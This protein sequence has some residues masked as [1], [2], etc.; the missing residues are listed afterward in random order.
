MFN[1]HV[2]AFLFSVFSFLWLNFCYAAS[3]IPADYMEPGFSNKRDY[4]GDQPNEYIDPFGGS[5]HLTYK[6]LVV[7]GNGGM[8]IVV[9]RVY[10]SLTETG[11]YLSNSITGGGRTTTGIGWDVHFGRVWPNGTNLLG[12][13][14]PAGRKK[15]TSSSSGNPVL[16]LADG[17]RKT[18]VDSDS[19][20]YS[21]ITKD[22]WIAKA[23]TPAEDVSGLGGLRVISPEGTE[24]LFTHKNR[25]ALT[26]AWSEAPFSITKITD[27]NGNWMQFYYLN[28]NFNYLTTF[29]GITTSDGRSVSFNYDYTNPNNSTSL[30]QQTSKAALRSITIG[31]QTVQYNYSAYLDGD[32]FQFL[33]RVVRPDN[34]N[35]NYTYY[36]STDPTG[37]YSLW[38]STSPASVKSTYTYAAVGFYTYLLGTPTNRV[39]SQKT[40]SGGGVTSG[41]WNYAYVPSTGGTVNDKTTVTSPF[42]C[43]VYQHFGVRQAASETVWKIGTLASKKVYDNTACT[44]LLHQEDY[45]WD[46]LTVAQQNAT[47][48]YISGFDS[49]TYDAKQVQKVITRDGTTYTTTYPIGNFDIYGNPQVVTEA[50]QDTKTTNYTYYNDPTKWI[51]GK[52]DK[53]TIVSASSHGDAIIDRTFDTLGRVTKQSHFSSSSTTNTVDTTYSYY[54]TG[55]VQRVTDAENNYV[56]YSNYYRGIPQAENYYDSSNTL[57]KSKSR[58]VDAAANIKSEIDGR[59][60]NTIYSYDSLNRLK[61]VIKPKAGSSAINITWT[62]NSSGIQ[63]VV[64]RG[65]YSQTTQ[66][67]GLGRMLSQSDNSISR[68]FTND[69]EGRQISATNPVVSSTYD[70]LGRVKTQTHKN[71]ANNNVSV[72][73]LYQ[74]AN[75]VRIT[76]EL[77]N[78]TTYSYL[79]YGNPD[80]KQ[81]ISIAA[82]HSVTTTITRSGT[83]NKLGLVTSVTQGGVTRS[84]SYNNNLFLYQEINPETGTTTYGRDKLGRMTSRQVGTSAITNFV[85][86]GLGRLKIANYPTGTDDVV[87]TYDG[88]DN[89]DTTTKGSNFWAYT[90][91]SN[92]NL[93]S[94][95]LTLN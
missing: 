93:E 30:I 18:L 10:H 33:D 59:G 19:T 41:T 56:I 72:S 2:L 79:S 71:D 6:D 40:V 44:T 27:K 89:L 94:E 21:F 65:T 5:L 92:D 8:D 74:A 54:A 12:S 78:V 45:T 70:Y 69:A 26:Q 77:S 23:I 4:T 88:N 31:A 34:T 91:D 35:W 67:D 62:E 15:G 53:E 64:T 42:G 39:I 37:L 81:V 29:S 32:N 43:T 38:T 90:Y 47:A 95:V 11:G 60:N 16:E 82:P 9:N 13:T 22:R 1:K 75:K 17:T 25:T 68:S 85:Y 63:K 66:Y 61:Q 14:N 58:V 3:A 24:Y 48:V 73:Y 57:L 49:N 36:P 83:A 7:R 76:D 86:D 84:Y 50:G 46:K 80:D 51:I 52:L 87:N 55:D 20:N 28:P